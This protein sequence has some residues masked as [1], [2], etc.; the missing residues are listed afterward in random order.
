MDSR[1]LIFVLALAILALVR[2]GMWM[3]K[4][5]GRPLLATQSELLRWD[6]RQLLLASFLTLFGELAFIRLIAVEVRVFAYFKNLALLLCF[7]GFGLGCALVNERVRWAT[8]INAFLGLVLIVRFP[9]SQ[10]PLEQLSQNLAAASDVQIWYAGSSWQW[11][12]FLNATLL[13]GALFLLI[14]LIFIPLGQIVSQQMNSAARPLSAYSWNLLGSLAGILAFLATSRLMLPPTFWLGAVLLGFAGLQTERRD[15]VLVVSLVIPLL[16]LLH[17]PS[18][19]GK[20]V[21]WTPYQQI[22]YLP[23]YASNGDLV[24]PSLQ[25]ITAVTRAS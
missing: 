9:W 25:S 13:A 10:E 22:Q 3:A 12:P 16:L 19:N 4:R 1:L 7:V 5:H 23:Q 24:R 18:Q 2:V 6:I 21:I 15:R 14:V 20:K 17:E 11:L 8:A